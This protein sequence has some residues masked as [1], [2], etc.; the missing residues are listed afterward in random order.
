MGETN[1]EKSNLN[2]IK[3]KN[4]FIVSMSRSNNVIAIKLS[5]QPERLAGLSDLWS[6]LPPSLPDFLGWP[7]TAEPWL[8]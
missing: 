1:K 2:L 6:N 3:I 8:L 7:G 4:F 5:R